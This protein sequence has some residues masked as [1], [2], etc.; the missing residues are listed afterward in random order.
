[1]VLQRAGQQL[2]LGPYPVCLRAGFSPQDENSVLLHWVAKFMLI[3]L[4][5]L[6]SIRIIESLLIPVSKES[7]RN[8][9][10]APLYLEHCPLSA[11]S[12]EHSWV[13]WWFRCV[14]IYAFVESR[15]D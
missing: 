15:E 13:F 14:D 2:F 4:I 8:K 9:P 12:A 10:R 11:V 3:Y 1:M 6:Y 5:K 7:N